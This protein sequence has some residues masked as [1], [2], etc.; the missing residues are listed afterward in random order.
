MILFL[1]KL[2]FKINLNLKKNNLSYII[3]KQ[4]EIAKMADNEIDEML[5]EVDEIGRHQSIREN[6]R[7]TRN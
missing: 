1:N 7:K 6:Q 4:L 5:K 2:L 3:Q